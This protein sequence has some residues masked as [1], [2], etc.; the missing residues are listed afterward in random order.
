[1]ENFFGVGM[2]NAKQVGRM[3]AFD[4]GC[5]QTLPMALQ[6]WTIDWDACWRG[7]GCYDYLMHLK[8]KFGLAERYNA[9]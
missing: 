8:G 2:S 7:V 6:V 3:R 9:M 1:M 5:S 4:D